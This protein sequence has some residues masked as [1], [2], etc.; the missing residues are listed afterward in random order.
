MRA[1]LL[2]VCAALLSRSRAISTKTNLR[3]EHSSIHKLPAFKALIA[4]TIRT[5]SLSVSRPCQWSEEKGVSPIYPRWTDHLQKLFSDMAKV[6][7][8]R[9]QAHQVSLRTNWSSLPNQHSI[10]HLLYSVH[11]APFRFPHYQT[12]PERRLVRRKLRYLDYDDPA[13]PSP[14]QDH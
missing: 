6:R 9:L 11:H 4:F 5:D 10:H 12:L 2:F 8:E 14:L 1:L 3:F 13:T 7:N